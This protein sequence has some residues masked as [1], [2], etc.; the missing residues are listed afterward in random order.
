MHTHLE[1]HPDHFKSAGGVRQ[2]S[3]S[4]SRPDG[5]GG[6]V[7]SMVCDR[8]CLSHFTACLQCLS[9]SGTRSGGV[10]ALI[11]HAD[12]LDNEKSLPVLALPTAQKPHTYT[13]SGANTHSKWRVTTTMYFSLTPPLFISRWGLGYLLI[14]SHEDLK[15]QISSN[16]V[17]M[18]RNKESKSLVMEHIFG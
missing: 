6:L 17:E 7:C 16:W 4:S 10:I 11:C 13:Y 14:L 2:C 5:S 8:D 1:K 12:R 3:S 9:E 15:S 18:K